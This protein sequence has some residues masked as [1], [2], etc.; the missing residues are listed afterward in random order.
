MEPAD[1][2][3]PRIVKKHPLFVVSGIMIFIGICLSCYELYPG[4]VLAWLGVML[5]RPHWVCGACGH[6]VD[7]DAKLCPSCWHKLKAKP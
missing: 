1:D 7:P 5:D 2:I 3:Q 6:R 4:L